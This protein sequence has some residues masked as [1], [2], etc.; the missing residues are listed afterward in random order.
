MKSCPIILALYFLAWTTVST[1]A[2]ESVHLDNTVAA[3][4]IFKITYFLGL[5]G[6]W[7]DSENK[8][9]QSFERAMRSI[10]RDLSNFSKSV[11]GSK[12]KKQ[13]DELI[14]F[15]S[16]GVQSSVNTDDSESV[17][18]FREHGLDPDKTGAAELAILFEKRIAAYAVVSNTPA[19]VYDNS[20][21]EK[22]GVDESATLQQK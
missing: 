11:H 20:K 19:W 1:H 13:G 12:L 21:R 15:I 7:S 2:D 4:I 9:P 22:V 10:A 6:T 16:R 3:G 8:N 5:E 17:D 14:G 18:F